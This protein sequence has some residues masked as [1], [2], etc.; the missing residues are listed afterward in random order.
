MSGV[1][2]DQDTDSTLQAAASLLEALRNEDFE[3]IRQAFAL[4]LRLLIPAQFHAEMWSQMIG[5][6]GPIDSITK[7]QYDSHGYFPKVKALV[8]FQRG[9]FALAIQFGPYQSVLG[10]K[11]HAPIAMDLTEPWSAP[12]Y[13]DE[14]SFSET[15]F[16]INP[17]WIFPGAEA[18]LT[19]P[20]STGKKPAILFLQGSGISD[21]DIG[22]GAQQPAK[23]MAL[24]LASA[25][26]VVLRIGKPL[27]WL[28]YKTRFAGN[29]TAIDEYLYTGIEALRYLARHPEVDPTQI[30]VLGI[31]MGGRFAPR[32]CQHSPVPVAGMISVAG[33]A[34]GL[35]EIFMHQAQYYQKHF[36][37]NQ[38]LHLSEASKLRE[39]SDALEKQSL[40]KNS[41]NPISSL[42][43]PLPLSYFIDDHQNSPTQTIERLSIRT[44]IIQGLSDWQVPAEAN[45]ALWRKSCK[46]LTEQGKAVLKTYDGLPHTM[47][48]FEGD[49]VGMRQ[50][51]NP[52][53]VAPVVITDIIA[54]IKQ[55]P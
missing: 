41:P 11:I 22:I 7:L 18:S 4:P 6:T 34:Q 31:S 24:G 43:I 9:T 44:L 15:R 23:D 21:L 16:K 36:P 47:V 46:T 51:D 35:C 54:W 8:R 12:V 10:M 32:L 5:M 33:L 29:L 26:I 45:I 28:V 30:F 52:G 50:Y 13:V 53:H 17:F 2:E 3:V 37:K 1:T 48:P 55:K 27:A 40:T 42:S 20:K 14:D 38:E 19:V 39:L 49:L 25:G